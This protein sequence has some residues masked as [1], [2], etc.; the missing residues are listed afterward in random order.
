VT[1]VERRSHWDN[2]Y[3]AKAE[4][5]VSWFQE[6]PTVS[7]ALIKASGLARESAIIDIG[8]GA[9]RLVDVLLDEGFEDLTVLDISESA[10]E[11]AKARLGA[12]AKEVQWVVA[13]VTTWKPPRH[14]D[15]WHDRAALH[16]LI[17]PHDRI[18]YGERVAM[19]V[20]PGGHVIIGT[21]ALDGPERCSG[22]PVMR[23]DTASL[24]HMLG[25]EFE[26][27]E[28]RRHDH[29]TPTGSTQRFQFSRFRRVR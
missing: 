23:H 14:Y 21:F 27:V 9:S 6:S 17:D 4:N 18:A 12:R 24:A 29:R 2:V 19:G 1:H 20:R 7:L 5:E 22:L 11:A 8:G 16:F 13:D 3:T 26:P 28:T 10:V 25:P 15:L